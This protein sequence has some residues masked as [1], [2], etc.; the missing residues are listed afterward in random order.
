VDSSGGEITAHG[1][2]FQTDYDGKRFEFGFGA[3]YRLTVISQLYM[4]YEYARS[5][6]YERPWSLTLGYRKLW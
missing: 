2:T 4:D 5:A 1:K 6:A 3:T